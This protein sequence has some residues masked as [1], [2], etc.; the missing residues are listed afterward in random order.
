MPG[1]LSNR[2]GT[3]R[4][5]LMRLPYR[6]RFHPTRLLNNA[7]QFSQAQQPAQAVTSDFLNVMAKFHEDTVVAFSRGV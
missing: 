6:P 3:D 1:E 7:G 4:S 5:L 2:V